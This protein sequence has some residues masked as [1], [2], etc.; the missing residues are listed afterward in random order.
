MPEVRETR[1]SIE[2]GGI[3]AANALTAMEALLLKNA[4]KLPTTPTQGDSSA[5]LLGSADVKMGAIGIE[6]PTDLVA[7]EPFDDLLVAYL[8]EDVEN[9]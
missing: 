8:I 7:G 4:P 5:L 9:S 1:S 6:F 3:E 2:P